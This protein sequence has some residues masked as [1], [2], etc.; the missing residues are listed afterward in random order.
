MKQN[1]HCILKIF[2]KIKKI[3]IHERIKNI[4]SF[5]KKISS[6]QSVSKILSSFLFLQQCLY[7]MYCE[8]PCNYEQTLK[9]LKRGES[10]YGRQRS[11]R[12]KKKTDLGCQLS[13]V[14][15]QLVG[16]LQWRM[17]SCCFAE[18]STVGHKM[19]HKSDKNTCNPKLISAMP[20]KKFLFSHD[21]F[22]NRSLRI[23]FAIQTTRKTFYCHVQIS[24]LCN[25]VY[26]VLSPPFFFPSVFFF[27]FLFFNP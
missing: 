18:K 21:L 6:N 9:K 11:L 16:M 4:Y 1:L 2:Q 23:R 27:L 17:S 25:S 15:S 7:R 8:I 13:F 14:H 5:Q 26:A 12:E 24:I 10:N 20:G 19:E 22:S 3:S